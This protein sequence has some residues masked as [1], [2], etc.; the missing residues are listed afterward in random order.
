MNFAKVLSDEQ[1]DK[2]RRAG[3]ELLENT[4]FKVEDDEAL[5]RCAA[6]GAKVNSASG[7]VRIPRLLLGELL[8]RAPSKYTIDSVE[9]KTYE[10]GGPEQWG[11]AIVTDPWII[12]YNTQKPRRPRLDDLRRH[13]AVAQSMGHVAVVSRMDF[14]VSDVEGPV[15]TG[16]TCSLYEKVL[17]YTSHC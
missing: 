17:A 10:I 12:D 7:I 3:E 15:S 5:R 9:G 13:T 16:S 2:I 8:E 4:G 6:A 14:P 1:I 11:V